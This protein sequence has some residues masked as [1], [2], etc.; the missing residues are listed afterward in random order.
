LYDIGLNALKSASAIQLEDVAL[1]K[2]III[3]DESAFTKLYALY[4]P[5]LLKFCAGYLKGISIK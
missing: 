2:A 4:Q 5:R 1:L 3:R